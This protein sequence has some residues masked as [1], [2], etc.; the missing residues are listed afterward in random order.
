MTALA[1]RRRPFPW[2]QR[3]GVGDLPVT[4]LTGVEANAER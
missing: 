2:E 3:E 1:C 4:L